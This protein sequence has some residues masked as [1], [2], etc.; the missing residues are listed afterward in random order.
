MTTAA[1]STPAASPRARGRWRPDGPGIVLLL[2]LVTVVATR[3]V[4][5]ASNI[6]RFE[7]DEAVTGVMA[8]RI[9][10]G[11]F[12]VY[13]GI[14]SYQGALEQ[15]LQAPLLALF[16]DTPLVL[17]LVQVALS[18]VICILV[19]IIGKH[20]LGSRWGA[21]LAA[22][23]FAVGPYFLALKSV[24]SHGGYDG[25]VLFGL[26]VVLLALALNRQSGRARWVALSLG[27]CGGLALWEN[28]G[29]VYLLIP[30]AIWA[31]GSMRGAYR[32]LL[33]WGI[34]GLIVG[35]LP[36]IAFRALHGINPPSGTGDPP[37][38]TVAQRM[39]LLL[40][41]VTGQFLGVRSGAPLLDRFVPAALITVIALGVLGAAVW[42]RRR[43]LWEM[44]TLTTSRRRPVD[45]ILL[46]F[47]LA[48]FIYAASTY[49]WYAGEPRYLFP[50]Y[51]F[52]AIG[53]AA[54][55]FAV[56][57][58]P[59][60]ILAIGV[61][62]LSA[63]L[64]VGTIRSV[65]LRGGEFTSSDGGLIYTEDLPEVASALSRQG[66]DAVYADYWVANPLQF[67]TGQGVAVASTG[68]NHFPAIAGRVAR[69][70][71]PAIVSNSGPGADGM[72]ATLTASGRRFSERVVGRF[73]IFWNIAPPWRPGA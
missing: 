52:L 22:A 61:T 26:L 33:P 15:Y 4:L 5:L 14:Q 57:G 13:F 35:L 3:M 56:R 10:D 45:I 30:A 72:R 2:A 18:A 37:D 51:P 16:P 20:V 71:D 19:F 69:D 70:A 11:D 25:A 62:A 7:S 38:T 68:I 63:V 43:G 23:L 27:V 28:A 66:I 34:G 48:P 9:L 32:R 64:L 47:L 44:V 49:T 31:L 1:A 29:S 39:D 12:P 55:I 50:L 36:V 67:F 73:T 59:R 53:V 58:R 46:A 40:S 24:R 42:A 65:Y 41:P 54:A 8:Q 17:R 6:A 21:A 60:L